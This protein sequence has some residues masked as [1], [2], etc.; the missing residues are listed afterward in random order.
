[1]NISLN[2]DQTIKL[3]VLFPVLNA[4]VYIFI[5][6]YL[7]NFCMI[8]LEETLS[9][10]S[11]VCFRTQSMKSPTRNNSVGNPSPRLFA[12]G[13]GNVE[14]R[15]AEGSPP[16][17]LI[18]HQELPDERPPSLNGPVTAVEDKSENET[19]SQEA[20]EDAPLEATGDIPLQD[21]DEEPDMMREESDTPSEGHSDA[22]L[23]W[24]A[25]PLEVAVNNE[26]EAIINENPEVNAEE[27]EGF[28]HG[29]PLNFYGE[30]VDNAGEED[31]MVPEGCVRIEYQPQPRPP[32]PLEVSDVDTLSPPPP[33]PPPPHED[34]DEDE[35]PNEMRDDGV[36]REFPTPPPEL[37]PS[38]PPELLE[39]P[40]K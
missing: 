17:P 18:P 31:V 12:A 25:E 34:G 9:N 4:T 30:D 3:I 39:E 37:L 32:T 35:F 8:L 5:I 14:T 20:A 10:T 27:D 21:L 6:Y 1:M 28:E 26:A 33:S 29:T 36:G 38:P 23:E 19:H 7:C 13:Y 16:R 22:E 40:E 15:V 11:A 2:F 24:Q